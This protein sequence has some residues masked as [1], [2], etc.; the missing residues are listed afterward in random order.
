[1][2]STMS[3][4]YADAVRLCAV[5]FVA[6][7]IV[8]NLLSTQAR[9]RSGVSN[10]KEETSEITGYGSKV[11]ESGLLGNEKAVR[12]LGRITSNNAVNEPI[13]MAL[14]IVGL[15][16]VRELSAAPV[17]AFMWSRCV[18]NICFL[19]MPQIGTMAPRSVA[20]VTSMGA[21]GLLAYQ[22]AQ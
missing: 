19:F 1:M 3:A 21:A 2:G 8:F 5:V 10:F 15:S 16:S 9:M 22:L 14:A 18:H 20:F 13:F 6:K 7:G 17:A 11:K 12:V 4:P